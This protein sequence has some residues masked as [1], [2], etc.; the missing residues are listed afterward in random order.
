M[1]GL[2]GNYQIEVEK[3]TEEAAGRGAVKV[4]AQVKIIPEPGPGRPAS[5]PVNSVYTVQN[6]LINWIVSKIATEAA[7]E[8]PRA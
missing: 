8:P 6:G 4:T 7:A 1:H 2:H 3:I 5:V